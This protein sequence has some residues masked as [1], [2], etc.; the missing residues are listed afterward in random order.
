VNGPLDDVNSNSN[1]EEK[2]TQA[3]AA[4][5]TCFLRKCG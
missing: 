3:T 5:A 4:C 1:S 2:G